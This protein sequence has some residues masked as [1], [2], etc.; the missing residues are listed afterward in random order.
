MTRDDLTDREY[1]ALARFRRAL[2]QFNATSEDAAKA[3]GI[4]PQQHQLLLAIRGWAGAGDPSI[5]DLA[6]VL[7]LR[8][9]STVELLQRARVAGIVAVHPDPADARRQLVQLTDAGGLALRDLYR[10]HG[11]E[12]RRFRRNMADVLRELD[13]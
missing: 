10:V 13:G 11:D 2:R 5:S 9:H 6:E 12:L 3:I 7:H 4:T 8:H 1:V